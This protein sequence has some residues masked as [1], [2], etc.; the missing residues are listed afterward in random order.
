MLE[1]K[2]ARLPAAV[3]AV[4][5]IPWAGVLLPSLLLFA[6]SLGLQAWTYFEAQRLRELAR[7]EGRAAVA[8]VEYAAFQG[9][10]VNEVVA[11]LVGSA[12]REAVLAFYDRFTQSREVS[13]LLVS[14]AL[15]LD[16]PVHYLVGLAWA[17]SRFKP[18][19]INGRRN[20]NGTSD[21]GLMQLNSGEYGALGITY[22]MEPAHNVRLGAEHLRA[23]FD[24]YHDW[25]EAILSYNAGTGDTVPRA[26]VRHVADVLDYAHQLDEAFIAGYLGGRR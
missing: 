15:S 5:R 14:S 9:E 3:P 23:M 18:G 6:A 2:S 8:Q 24:R 19:A 4:R 11:D 12:Q 1:A 20:A 26:S 25:P 10:R 7:M 16:V 17:E 21:Y 22:I 13:F